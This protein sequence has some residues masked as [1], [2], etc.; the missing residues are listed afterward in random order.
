MLVVGTTGG[1]KPGDQLA[2]DGGDIGGVEAEGGAEIVVRLGVLGQSSD[3]GLGEG[4]GGG[5]GLLELGDEIG[6]WLRQVDARAVE[7]AEIV[8]H[9]NG[10]AQEEHLQPQGA[11]QRAVGCR[12]IRRQGDGLAEQLDGFVVL[13]LVD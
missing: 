11:R 6:R 3:V 1:A 10:A 5:D 9:R 8:I 2:V 4:E 12:L 13:V 7:R